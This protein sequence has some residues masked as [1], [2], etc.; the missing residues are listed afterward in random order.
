MKLTKKTFEF[1]YEE[2]KNKALAKRKT[3]KLF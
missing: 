2:G 3:C 1:D